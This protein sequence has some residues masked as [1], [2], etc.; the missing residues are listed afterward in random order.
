MFDELKLYCEHNELDV[1]FISPDYKNIVIND[2]YGDYY[3]SLRCTKRGVWK[4][5]FDSGVS[6][7]E[8][9]LKLAI[10]LLSLAKSGYSVIDSEVN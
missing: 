5:N 3:M 8:S 9:D 10:K 1:H 7:Y 4:V 2:S 6:L